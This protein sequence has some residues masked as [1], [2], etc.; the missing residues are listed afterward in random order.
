MAFMVL[1]GIIASSMVGFIRF[2]NY[3]QIFYL[4]ALADFVY[5]LFRIKEHFLIRLGTTAWTLLILFVLYFG[6]YNTT[7]TYF[8]NFFYPYTCI[9]DED[10]SVYFRETAHQEALELDV[11]DD[12]VREIE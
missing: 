5:T 12:N 8:Y 7:D 9:L 1:L 2:Y 4:I 6:H 10:D 11:K 3:V